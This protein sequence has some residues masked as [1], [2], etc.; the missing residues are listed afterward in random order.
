MGEGAKGGTESAH[1]NVTFF[2]MASLMAMI[3]LAVKI[4]AIMI[5]MVIMKMWIMKMAMMMMAVMMMLAVM[6]VAMMMM[7]AVFS[8]AV[9]TA[10]RHHMAG[11][12]LYPMHYGTLGAAGTLY[13]TNG[14][15]CCT[16]HNV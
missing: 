8:G 3:M 13:S 4:V 7:A 5:N 2:L 15:L 6:I 12:T 16:R 10:S 1:R 11:P 14:T 9:L